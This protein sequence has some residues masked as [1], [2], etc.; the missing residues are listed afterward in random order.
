[1]KKMKTLSKVD[2]LH[3]LKIMANI[4]NPRKEG[5]RVRRLSQ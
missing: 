4:H 3:L 2:V 1:M 5:V